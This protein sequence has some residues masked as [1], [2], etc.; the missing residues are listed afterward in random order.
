MFSKNPLLAR[1]VSAFVAIIS[2]VTLVVIGG[3]GGLA[4]AQTSGEVTITGSQGVV[5]VVSVEGGRGAIRSGGGPGGA[6]QA[7][8]W[9]YTCQFF[10][11]VDLGSIPVAVTAPRDGGIYHLLCT[12]RPGTDVEPINIPIYTYNAGGDFLDVDPTLVSSVQLREFA[13]DI[14]DPPDL[15]IGLSP[16]DQQITGVETWFWPDG[17]RGP[18]Q[19]SASAGELTVTIEARFV[20]AEYI[21]SGA[22]EATVRCTEFTEWSPGAGDSPCATTLFEQTPAQSIEAQSTWQLVWWDNA[23]QP[24][25]IELGFITE[26]QIEAVEVVDL[27]A[28]IT[29]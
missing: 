29:R 28:V 5:S 25:P 15:G 14:I 6:P 1:S 10:A 19:V 22:N 26:T 18:Q 21:L 24:T 13:Q 23:G 20:Q 2:F 8:V 16:A 27:E 12:P 17:D 7:S 11:G 9:P 4:S 3:V